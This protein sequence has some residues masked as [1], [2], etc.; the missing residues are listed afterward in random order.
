MEGRKKR[1]ITHS[2]RSAGRREPIPHRPIFPVMRTL[3]QQSWAEG[4]GAGAKAARGAV[5]PCASPFVPSLPTHTL[6]L[7]PSLSCAGRIR[8]EQA[9][10]RQQ[11][12]GLAAGE[13]PR[14]AGGGGRLVGALPI[15]LRSPGG[16]AE[17]SRRRAR[18]AA[19][20]GCELQAPAGRAAEAGGRRRP[21]H[22]GVASASGR[23]ERAAERRGSLSRWPLVAGS[24]A[25]I[26]LMTWHDVVP[27]FGA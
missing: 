26:F 17:D 3:Q 5:L 18:P 23:E 10:S 21:A 1:R 27:P 11:E 2:W 6:S 15:P 8:G 24:T 13:A 4:S 20:G 14:R 25:T 9:E 12:L 7:P 16:G 22:A 19:E